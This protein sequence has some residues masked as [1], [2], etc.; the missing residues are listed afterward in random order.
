MNGIIV[1]AKFYMKSGTIIDESVAVENTA[2]DTKEFLE[3][4]KSQIKRA[5][6]ECLNGQFTFGFT[7]FR[8]TEIEAVEL[9]TE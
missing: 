4:Y 8:S 3:K 6:T 7:I 9:Y 1:K 2:E 5:F